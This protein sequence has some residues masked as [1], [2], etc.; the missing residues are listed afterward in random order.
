MKKSLLMIV[1]LL[2]LSGCAVGVYDP[3]PT[4]V[5]TTP[6][7]TIVVEQSPILISPWGY[8]YYHP[9]PYRY[10]YYHGGHR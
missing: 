8:G 3:A 10:Y 5:Y 6:T 9:H 2:L 7:S 4:T 1:G